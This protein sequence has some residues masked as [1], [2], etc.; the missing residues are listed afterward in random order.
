MN[1]SQLYLLGLITLIGFP[2][3]GA[4]IIWLLKP[5]GFQF[6]LVYPLYQQVAIGLL[7]GIIFGFIALGVSKMPFMQPVVAKYSSMLSHIDFQWSDILFISLCAGVGEE[8]FFRGVL[9]FYWGI[10]PTAIFFV[11]IHGYL[12]PRN[13]RLSIYGTIMV[14]LIAALGYVNDHIGLPSAMIAHTVIDIVLLYFM[15]QTNQHE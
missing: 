15:T 2:V 8:Y 14:L 11:A 6:S 7:I 10:W 12:D 1:K 5:E 13:W 9:Q 3:I 4:L